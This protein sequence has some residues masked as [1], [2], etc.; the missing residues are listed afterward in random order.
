MAIRWLAAFED[1]PWAK[2]REM[3]P[4]LVEGAGKLWS[5]WTRKDDPEPEVARPLAKPEQPVAEQLAELQIRVNA[6]EKRVAQLKDETTAS[7]EVVKSITEQHSQL[8]HA[9]DLLIARTR[10]LARVCVLLA[11][12]LIVLLV[13][14]IAR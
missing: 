6:L 2:V 13:L 11:A 12:G 5:R 1:I 10:V 8:V 7:F 3:A 4:S 14:A 9:M